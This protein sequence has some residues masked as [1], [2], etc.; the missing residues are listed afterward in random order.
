MGVVMVPKAELHVHLESVLHPTLAK[1]LSKKYDVHLPDTLF[2]DNDTYAYKNF[3]DFLKNYDLVA[4][5]LRSPEDYFDITYDYL[6][7]SAKEGVIYSELILS[8][9]HAKVQGLSF[10]AVSSAVIDGIK[11]AKEKTGIESR[12]LIAA[13]RHLGTEAVEKSVQDTINHASPFVVGINLVGNPVGFSPQMFEKAFAMAREAK[14]G[15]VA[16]AGETLGTESMSDTIKYLKVSRIG[17]GVRC[18]EDPKVMAEIKEK[19]ITLELC[20]T[21]NVALKVFSSYDQYPMRKIYD[22]GIKVTL[23]SDDPYF[24]GSTIDQEYQIAQTKFGFSEKELINITKTAIENSFAKENVKQN[25][26]KK[27]EN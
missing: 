6:I 10:P 13:V 23:N 24:F 22:F 17:H 25:L 14:L 18:I 5:C 12:I 11:A 4:S 3:P 7:R 2:K 19:Q 1:R 20:P 8:N 16:H 26:L 21:S 27:L 9:D 15:L